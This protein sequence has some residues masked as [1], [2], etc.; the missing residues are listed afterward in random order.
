MTFAKLLVST[1]KALS[2]KSSELAKY[3]KKFAIAIK[4]VEDLQDDLIWFQSR[5]IQFH[6]MALNN[7]DA[8]LLYNEMYE[9]IC[10][11]HGYSEEEMTN[12]IEEIVTAT[13]ID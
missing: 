6:I 10:D 8:S 9:V 4:E 2:V 5:V 7:E 13:A 12:W 1:V 3:N 11:Q